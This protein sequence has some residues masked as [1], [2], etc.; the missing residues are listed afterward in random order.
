MLSFSARQDQGFRAISK[1]GRE[2]V[3]KSRSSTLRVNHRL[4]GNY[5]ENGVLSGL[6]TIRELSDESA[7]LVT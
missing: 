3:H 7:F 2:L 1:N 4:S 5:P 6:A